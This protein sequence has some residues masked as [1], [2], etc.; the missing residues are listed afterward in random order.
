VVDDVNDPNGSPLP[1]KT[2]ELLRLSVAGDERDPNAG[3]D[4]GGTL[5]TRDWIA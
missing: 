2:T 3:F 5:C 1:D 4:R